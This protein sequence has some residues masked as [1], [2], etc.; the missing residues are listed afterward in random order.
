M[1]SY[2]KE[3][4]I[5]ASSLTRNFG[6]VLNKFN[7]NELEKIAVLRNNKIEAVILS[8]DEYEKLCSY[9]EISEQIEIAN[10]ITDRLSKNSE[11]VK[12]ETILNELGLNYDDL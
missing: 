11:A 10:L 9:Y 5:S 6:E 1:I 8:V 4:L 12:F 3:E 2:R 7:K